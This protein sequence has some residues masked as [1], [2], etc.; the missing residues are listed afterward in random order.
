MNSTMVKF[1]ERLSVFGVMRE[2]C[3]VGVVEEVRSQHSSKKLETDP[4]TFFFLLAVRVT[5]VI[6]NDGYAPRSHTMQIRVKRGDTLRRKGRGSRRF[7]DEGVAGHTPPEGGSHGGAPFARNAAQSPW[8]G[9]RL[10]GVIGPAQSGV[11]HS[12]AKANTEY[13][14]GRNCPWCGSLT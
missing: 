7:K 4:L 2:W 14:Y 8:W 1:E 6:A 5:M 10:R 13:L 11:S 3:R 9:R 12:V